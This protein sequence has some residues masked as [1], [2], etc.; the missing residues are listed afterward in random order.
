MK[1]LTLLY[2]FFIIILCG[3]L[4]ALGK[5]DYKKEAADVY[6]NLKTTRSNYLRIFKLDK[7]F[8]N[9]WGL[10]DKKLAEAETFYKQGDY[11]TAKVG[12][13]KILKDLK[14]LADNRHK[15]KDEIAPTQFKPHEKD[16]CSVDSAVFRS[17][18]LA[19]QNGNISRAIELFYR[20]EN[21]KCLRK[22]DLKYA[23]DFIKEK[24]ELV[25]TKLAKLRKAGNFA[26]KNRLIASINEILKGFKNIEPAW[27]RRFEKLVA[28]YDATGPGIKAEIEPQVIPES[29]IK[30]EE[31]KAPELKK[32]EYKKTERIRA[33]SAGEPYF[34]AIDIWQSAWKQDF[35]A[36]GLQPLMNYLKKNKII[37]INLNPG[38]PMGPGFNRDSY[39]KLKPI[40]AAFYAA[41][42]KKINFLYA[43]L[44]YPIGHF[45]E[46]LKKHPE[47]G[48]DT[49]VD[50]S[51]FTDFFKDK[52]D[53]N[54]LAVHNWGLK[55]SAFST[56][57][58]KGNSGVSDAT[59]FWMLRNV[60][61]PI[62]MSYFDCTTAGQKKILAK[63]LKYADSL[64]KRGTV[65]IAVLLGGK[66]VG[67]EVSCE[68][69][70]DEAAMQR[71]LWDL[72]AWA[73]R[74]HPSYRGIVIETNLRQPIYNIH[75]QHR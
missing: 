72:D 11:Y 5:V 55:Y 56:L 1:K 4:T 18:Y 22:S 9:R 44:D 12:F 7:K 31:Y 42:V 68:R 40:V 41:G 20:L 2:L 35:T 71:Y 48:I 26:Q 49:I 16:P 64:G 37:H 28:I 21:S 25:L 45:A 38:L 50:D 8:E 6:R 15:L 33:A 46:F 57:E 65:S 43:E 66:S 36:K 58:V 23:R 29:N 51:E 32:S 34:L 69:L 60:D 3:Y 24:K 53:R 39:K 62:L 59:R 17:A 67:R 75:L 61:F 10:L 14:Y 27:T 70:L 54:L 63:Y 74:N 47:L 73:R 19:E 13:E 30:Q 52:F